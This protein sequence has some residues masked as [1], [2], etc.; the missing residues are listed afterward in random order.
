MLEGSRS[1][2][3]GPDLSIA[4]MAV[5][6]GDGG[7]PLLSMVLARDG[8]AIRV[9]EFCLRYMDRRGRTSLWSTHS[10]G[11]KLLRGKATTGVDMLLMARSDALLLDSRL[12]FRWGARCHAKG[13]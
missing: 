5:L 12:F 8:S 9:G 4:T 1:P 7:G 3:D 10:I 6:N 11:Y 2:R 13:G